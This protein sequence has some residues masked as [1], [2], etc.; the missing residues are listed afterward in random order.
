MT[1]IMRAWITLV[2]ALFWIPSATPAPPSCPGGTTGGRAYLQ[3]GAPG[4]VLLVPLLKGY[5]EARERETWPKQPALAIAR[6]YRRL[7]ARAERL[8]GIRTWDD[9]FRQTD[10]LR[11]AGARYDRIVLIGHGGFDG[12][13]LNEK[14]LREQWTIRDAEGQ[15][16][17]VLETQPGIVDKLTVT[18]DI[19]RSPEFN[20]TLAR[21]WREIARKDPHEAMGMLTELENRLAP[22][23]PAC[24]ARRCPPE[25]L[26]ALADPA[27]RD[28]RLRACESVCRDPLFVSRSSEEAAPE[29]FL[30][31]AEALSALSHP[32]GLIMLGMCN[33]GT[34]APRHQAP[35]DIAG[36]LTR[37]NLAGGPHD[38]Y[39]HLLAAA[40]A[41]TVAGPVG[42]TSAADMV[43]RVSR[44]ESGR[45]QRFLRIVAPVDCR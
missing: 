23:D 1:R 19:S 38:T 13:L 33:P 36:V 9:F 8:D 18:Y 24:L 3:P 42:K 26:R 28:T 20:A 15:A 32:D 31:F 22:P 17:R 34:T 11:R 5:P 21:L 10:R 39:V 14:L 29:R 30:Q 4:A 27:A 41:R 44:L 35:W 2:L 37:S 40:T 43:E 7:G 16:V 25:E 12:P 6:L 45:A